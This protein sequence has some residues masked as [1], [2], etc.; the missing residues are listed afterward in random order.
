M[1]ALGS[2]V[3]LPLKKGDGI[4]YQKYAMVRLYLYGDDELYFLLGYYVCFGD[5]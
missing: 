3:T 4:V 5:A 2:E 1:V